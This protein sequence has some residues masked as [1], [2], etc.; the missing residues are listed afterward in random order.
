LIAE[1]FDPKY[2]ENKDKWEQMI[3]LQYNVDNIDD[4]TAEHYKMPI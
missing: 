4:A 1:G 3:K 2:F